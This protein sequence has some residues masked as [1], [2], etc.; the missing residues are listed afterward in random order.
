MRSAFFQQMYDL[1]WV[2]R[3]E[4]RPGLLLRGALVDVGLVYRG[5][6]GCAQEAQVLV[7]APALEACGMCEP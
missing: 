2:L 3:W 5:L 4:G 7:L 6:V 1:F